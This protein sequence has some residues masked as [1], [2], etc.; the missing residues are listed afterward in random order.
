MA[1]LY[2]VEALG[3]GGVSKRVV[4]KR[5]RAEQAKDPATLAM[6]LQEARVAS[7]L[8]HPNIVQTDDAVQTSA[9]YMLVM[10]HLVGSDL[11]A[12]LQLLPSALT[13]ARWVESVL[14]PKPPIAMEP[15]GTQAAALTAPVVLATAQHDR[16][17][18]VDGVMLLRLHSALDDAL[19]DGPLGGVLTDE[20]VVDWAEV[21]AMSSLG[22]HALIRVFER[23]RCGPSARTR[24]AWTSS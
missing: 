7:M 1:E 24:C 4:L 14:G 22:M 15:A 9:G 16:L 6:F 3:L 2:L 13:T 17:T 18:R 23:A 10:E 11:G 19:D 20:V 12:F 21:T 5:M 8:Q